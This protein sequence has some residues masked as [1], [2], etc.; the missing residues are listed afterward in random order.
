MMKNDELGSLIHC[1]ILGLCFG[2]WKTE[3]GPTFNADASSEAF[4]FNDFLV[5]R[6]PYHDVYQKLCA[7]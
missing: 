2:L 3:I 4:L 5:S 6:E 7:E 1:S